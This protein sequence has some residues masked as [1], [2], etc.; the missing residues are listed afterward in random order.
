MWRFIVCLVALMVFSGTA[1][2][3]RAKHH[4]NISS[5]QLITCDQR[6]CSDRQRLKQSVVVERTYIAGEGR[7]VG[8]RPHGAPYAFCGAEAS[9]YNFGRII[10]D[11]NLAS[12]WYHKFNRASA[13]AGMVAARNHHVMTLMHHVDG[14]NWMVHDGNSGGHL[15][16]EHVRSIAGYI[17][18]DPKSPRYAS[19]DQ[20]IR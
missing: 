8:G 10:P 12:N 16:R 15:T 1:E 7:I 13:A 18:V 19:R 20:T 17:I 11:L 9:I 2:A 5:S 4:R 14:L 6:G 3:R